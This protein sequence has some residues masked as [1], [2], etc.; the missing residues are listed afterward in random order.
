MLVEGYYSYD[1]YWQVGLIK[2]K[3]IIFYYCDKFVINLI[4]WVI[5]YFLVLILWM[6]LV[7]IFVKNENNYNGK[8]NKF[9]LLV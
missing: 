3:I 5:Y 4:E 9:F 7:L 2:N 8:F 1:I 6:I